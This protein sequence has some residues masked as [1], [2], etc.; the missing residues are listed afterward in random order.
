MFSVVL[1]L[2]GC[3]DLFF[4]F[5]LTSLTMSTST[6]VLTRGADKTTGNTHKATQIS[7]TDKPHN[8]TNGT[9]GNGTERHDTGRDGTGE[10][11]KA[12][13]H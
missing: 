11:R 9:E 4:L 3:S 8:A 5:I 13:V 2:C 12:N 1:F 6:S 7:H 10:R